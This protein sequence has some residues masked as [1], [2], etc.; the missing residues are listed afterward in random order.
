MFFNLSPNTRL[1]KK[2]QILRA[3]L[4]KIFEIIIEDNAL[5]LFLILHSDKATINFI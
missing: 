2:V 5:G 4:S 3:R 1:S